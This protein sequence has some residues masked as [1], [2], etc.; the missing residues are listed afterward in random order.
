MGVA[1]LRGAPLRAVTLQILTNVPEEAPA[2]ITDDQ[3]KALYNCSSPCDPGK[4]DFFISHSWS[5]DPLL[6]FEAL[7]RVGNQFRKEHRGREPIVWLDKI[8]INQTQ[9]DDDIRCLP[10]FLMSCQKLLVLCGKTYLSR[11]WCLLEL[12]IFFSMVKDA[13]HQ[14]DFVL[15]D[16]YDLHFKVENANCNLSND[17]ARLIEIIK[18]QGEGR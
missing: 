7:Q 11:L 1:R 14:T 8:C 16:A 12:Y 2:R 10:V 13:V 18:S 5:D 9:I 17:K 15:L 3:C 4:I 6:K